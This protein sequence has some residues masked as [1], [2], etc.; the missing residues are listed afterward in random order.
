VRRGP[1]HWPLVFLF[2]VLTMLILIVTTAAYQYFKQTGATLNYSVVASWLPKF[3][4]V[5]P[6][7]VSAVPLVIWLLLSAVLFYVVFG[8]LIVARAVERWRG[9]PRVSLV[10]SRGISFLGSTVLCLVALFLGSLSTL[11]V[12]SGLMGAWQSE[13]AWK[14][15]KSLLMNPFVNVTTTAAQEL[16]TEEYSAV[17]ADLSN[18]NSP[19]EANLQPTFRSEQRNVV[20]ILLESTRAQSVTP[21]NENLETTP[22]LDEL[23]KSSLLV[24]RAYTVVP[25]TS[26]AN[27]AVNCGIPPNVRNAAY[28]IIP[29]S[30][31]DGIPARCL[32]DLLRGQNY[33]TVYFQATNKD[34]ENWPTL[35][36]NFGYEEFY[37]IE[38]M[39]KEDKEGFE[40]VNYVEYETAYEDDILLKP[41]EEW[42]RENRAEPFLAT[43]LTA[44][45]HDAY[46]VPNRY[47]E[48]TFAED[49]ELNRYLNTIRYQDFF[50]KNLFDQ[51]KELGLYENT[52]F[53]VLGDHGEA[54]G[55][56]GARKHGLAVY[57]ETTRIPML[58]HDPRQFENGAR[59]EE[60]VSQLDVLP[61][62]ADLLGYEIVGG[63]YQGSSLLEPLPKD[64]TLLFSCLLEKCLGSVIGSEKY[65]YH[66]GDQPDELFDLSKDPLEQENLANER[67][68]EVHERRR[69]IFAWRSRIDATYRGPRE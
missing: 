33:N 22:F 15:S 62:M 39:S 24:E 32:P 69:E 28:G 16:G 66:Y 36:E 9:S 49:E 17:A 13:D 59:V 63:G 61:T 5:K 18:E 44:T 21:Y 48:K 1:L 31:P 14:F 56:H 40:R 67:P 38:S 27:V 64:R 10:G 25:W 7:V 60:P 35:V 12:N 20:L 51:Y 3:D 4:E 47:G 26:K 42:L 29:E 43:Y 11:P 19:M 65:I 2:H 68:E 57:E 50:L 8:P 58:I 41:S 23:A 54:F 46:V 34:F 30:A 52:V 37:P 45:P 53:V 55:E 6:M